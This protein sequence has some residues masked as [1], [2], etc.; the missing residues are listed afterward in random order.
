MKRYLFITTLAFL[1]T[2]CASRE[3][4]VYLVDI[5]QK[6]TEITQNYEPKLQP[7]DVLSIVVS[8]NAPELVA[9]FNPGVTMYQAMTERT[10]GQQRLQTYL[11]NGDGDIVFPVVGKVK[12]GGLTTTQATEE[13]TNVL[14]PHVVDA[15]VNLRLMNF[16]VTVQGEVARPGTFTVESERITLFQAL[17]LAGDIALYGKRDNILLIR[18][19]D[20]KR[21]YNRVDITKPD[22]MESEFYYLAPNDVVYVEPNKIRINSSAVGPNLTFALSA[23]SLL[24]TIV[25]IIISR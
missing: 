7:D 8:S 15:T 2:A 19:V 4:M 18:E 17:S 23:L 12:L 6:E 10:G 20:G 13:L 24:T 3:K 1:L 14:T 22:F 21:T 5:E 16:K 9:K 25:V 11:I